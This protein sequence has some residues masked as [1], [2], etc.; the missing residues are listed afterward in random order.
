MSTQMMLV[1]GNE[2]VFVVPNKAGGDAAKE[3]KIN[4]FPNSPWQTNILLCVPGIDI[5]GKVCTQKGPQPK[6]T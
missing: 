1:T 5:L 2:A 4:D 6:A 3:E